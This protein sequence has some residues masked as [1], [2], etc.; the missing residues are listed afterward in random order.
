MIVGVEET[1]EPVKALPD[2]LPAPIFVQ[3]GVS[4]VPDVGAAAWDVTCAYTIDP[5]PRVPDTYPTEVAI[6]FRLSPD[7]TGFQIQRDG[8]VES[9]VPGATPAT[10]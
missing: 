10:A 5:A 8:V 4:S 9:A 1:V 7:P 6:M 3:T 2:P